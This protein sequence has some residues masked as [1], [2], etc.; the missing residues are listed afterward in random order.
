[1]A[2]FVLECEIIIRL[3]IAVDKGQLESLRPLVWLCVHLDL[4]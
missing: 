3:T 2:S 1:M 4:Q